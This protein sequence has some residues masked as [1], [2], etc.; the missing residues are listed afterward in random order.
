MTTYDIDL[1]KKYLSDVVGE[2]ELVEGFGYALRSVSTYDSDGI[3]DST[4]LDWEAIDTEPLSV[5]MVTEGNNRYVSGEFVDTIENIINAAYMYGASATS[6]STVDATSQTTHGKFEFSNFDSSIAT[7]AQCLAITN[8]L[9]AKFK[10][11]QIKAAVDLSGTKRLLAGKYLKCLAPSVILQGSGINQN[12]Q[13]MRVTNHITTDNGWQQVCELGD[14][15]SD[16]SVL[17]SS[18]DARIRLTN[19]GSI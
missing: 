3:Y 11:P 16:D 9:V 19:I 12:M 8:P 14:I 4:H 7:N 10:D 5:P 6:G 13:I 18:L 17:L 15:Y 1:R 2:L